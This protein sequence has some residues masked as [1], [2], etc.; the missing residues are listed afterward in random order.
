MSIKIQTNAGVMTYEGRAWSGDTSEAAADAR[1]LNNY[2][3]PEGGPHDSTADRCMRLC[4]NAGMEPVLV[5]AD[6]N[7]DIGADA[8][9]ES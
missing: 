5:S 7:E 4:R 1:L 8:E 3:L 6:L 9:I 2:G